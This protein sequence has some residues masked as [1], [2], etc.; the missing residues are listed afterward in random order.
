MCLR[1]V[2]QRRVH[3]SLVS[4]CQRCFVD[5]F[6]CCPCCC[7]CCFVR[8]RASLT[9]LARGSR[10]PS[11]SLCAQG[12]AFFF[13]FCKSRSV[14]G[15]V[16]DERASERRKRPTALLQNAQLLR[17]KPEAAVRQTPGRGGGCRVR[18][19]FSSSARLTWLSLSLSLSPS[20]HLV[21]FVEWHVKRPRH[22]VFVLWL[23]S[24]HVRMCVSPCL[25]TS[26]WLPNTI[27]GGHQA[28]RE[29]RFRAEPGLEGGTGTVRVP[30][31]CGL[32]RFGTL[33]WD[34]RVG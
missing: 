25:R 32:C 28:G 10:A 23:A 33:Q 7:P 3:G 27:S 18:S 15:I 26:C 29:L 16:A 30:E 11:R 8:T 1:V 4:S 13:L 31:A 22:G 14:K 9:T 6:C 17:P 20:P 19:R 21:W 5:L 2:L 34:G 24:L 12:Q